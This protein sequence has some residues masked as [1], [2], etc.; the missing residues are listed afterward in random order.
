MTREELDMLQH[1]SG[2]ELLRSSPDRE[3]IRAL[4]KQACTRGGPLT[5]AQRER[6]GTIHYKHRRQHGHTTP[7]KFLK[8]ALVSKPAQAP[9]KK[10]RRKARAREEE[11]AEP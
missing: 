3:F 7:V 1:V 5:T 6:L 4:A 11:R 10:A 8:Q 2:C 9:Q